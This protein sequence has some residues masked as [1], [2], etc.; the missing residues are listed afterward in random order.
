MQAT[1]P[2]FMEGTSP[3]TNRYGRIYESWPKEVRA[4]VDEMIDYMKASGEF[5]TSNAV[6]K[7]VNTHCSQNNIECPKLNGQSVVSYT[8]HVR[9]LKWSE[10]CFK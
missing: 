2:T 8:L 7:N 10:I 1:L 5:F 6:A 3:A 9:E 4:L